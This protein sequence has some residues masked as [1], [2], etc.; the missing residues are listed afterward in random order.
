MKGRGLDLL[1]LREV[2]ES[3]CCEHGN[4]PPGLKEE[5]SFV[6]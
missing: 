4:E 1:S 6:M 2:Q 5:L 3:G